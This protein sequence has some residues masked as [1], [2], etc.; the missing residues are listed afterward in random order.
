MPEF[1]SGFQI[2]ALESFD[3]CMVDLAESVIGIEYA[4]QLKDRVTDRKSIHVNQK[5]LVVLQ[6]QVF[7]VVISVDHM[8]VMRNR[9]HK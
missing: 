9:F 4:G 3:S 7:G 1:L 2:Y 6:H 8:V 5:H